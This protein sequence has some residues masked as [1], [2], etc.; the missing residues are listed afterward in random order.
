[1]RARVTTGAAALGL[2]IAAAGFAPAAAAPQILGLMA[3]NGA[4]P[5]TCDGAA[6]RADLSTF[7]L[8]QARPMPGPGTAYRPA[9]GAALTIVATTGDGATVRLPG[10]AYL[11]FVSDRG[12][13]SVRVTLPRAR[14]AEIGATAAAIE[15]GERVSLLP[16]PV[17]GDPDPQ[18]PEEIA[19]ATGPLRRTADRFFN[20]GDPPAEAAR[21]TAL[22]V[23]ALPARG[24]SA[25]DQPGTEEALW[26]QAVGAEALATAA[27][28]ARD[29]ATGVVADCRRQVDE[30][31]AFSL[32]RCLEGGH[33]R[34]I[35]DTNIRFW[36]S[37]GGS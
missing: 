17:A 4:V 20:A 37:T 14:L 35:I 32:R 2:A 10:A 15:I 28:A 30:G 3:S 22:L 24:R 7:C 29:L 27:P 21:L 8:Q 11:S 34:L 18:T 12:Y 13:T 16:L 9:D 5:L 6:C 23:N 26:R 36:E 25:F 1:M 31:H 19:L 33:D